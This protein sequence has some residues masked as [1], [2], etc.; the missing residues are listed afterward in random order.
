MPIRGGTL[1]RGY[2]WS[3][4]RGVHLGGYTYPLLGNNLFPTGDREGGRV[5]F[6]G[7]ETLDSGV[8]I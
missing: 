7:L 8:L 3:L 5:H 4:G 6:D 1:R 2:T